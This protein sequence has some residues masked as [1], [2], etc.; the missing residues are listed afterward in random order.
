MNGYLFDT[1]TCVFRLRRMFG[2]D[3]RMNQVNRRD[4]YVS[5]IT[6]AELRFGAERCNQRKE[7]MLLVD[8]MYDEFTVL[9]ISRIIRTFAVEKAKLW[10]IG[11]KIPDFDLLIGATAVYHGLVLVTN[12]TKHFERM[13]S[14]QLE[15]WMQ[16]T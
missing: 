16:E 3:R 5:E 15:N 8:A 14:L 12:N 10:N 9:P 1:D 2:I 4:R 11:Q 7:Q 6:I 13:Q